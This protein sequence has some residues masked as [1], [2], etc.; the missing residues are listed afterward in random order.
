MVDDGNDGNDGQTIILEYW[1]SKGSR[2]IILRGFACSQLMH[3]WGNS[4]TERHY[5]MTPPQL[6]LAG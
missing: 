3:Q 2:L 4:I 5:W 1:Y 6:R